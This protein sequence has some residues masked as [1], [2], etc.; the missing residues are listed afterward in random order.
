VCLSCASDAGELQ[1]YGKRT[2]REHGDCAPLGWGS[3]QNAGA[4]MLGRRLSSTSN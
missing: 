3:A 4:L 2:G 1:R